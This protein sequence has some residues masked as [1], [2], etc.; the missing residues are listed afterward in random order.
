MTR[1]EALLEFAHG[2]MTSMQVF[3]TVE[4]NLEKYTGLIAA[5]GAEAKRFAVRLSVYAAFESEFGCSPETWR[6]REVQR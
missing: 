6:A 4:I 1:R 3:D 2:R 5:Q